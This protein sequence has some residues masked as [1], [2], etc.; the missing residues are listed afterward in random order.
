M[1]YCHYPQFVIFA[2]TGEQQWCFSQVKGTA[3]DDIAEGWFCVSFI[4]GQFSVNFIAAKFDWV[5]ILAC[6]QDRHF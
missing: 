3:D 6:M 2:A 5:G 4:A 1:Y